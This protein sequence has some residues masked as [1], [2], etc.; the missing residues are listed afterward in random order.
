[1]P[2][3]LWT[4]VYAKISQCNHDCKPNAEVHFFNEDHE[5]TLLALRKI[6]KGEEIFIT[7]I[8]DNERSD[9]K[10]RRAALRDYGFECDCEKCVNEEQW[11]RRL[12]PRRA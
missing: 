6:E 10:K 11:A 8:D 9:Y 12:R 5:A 2:E 4:A 1:M 7:Y 3:P